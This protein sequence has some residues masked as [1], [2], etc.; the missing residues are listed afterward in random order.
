MNI[1]KIYL[2]EGEVID[3]K[4][5]IDTMQSLIDT[6]QVLIEK[7]EKL[8]AGLPA[9][10][11]RVEEV[12]ESNETMLLSDFVKHHTVRVENILRGAFDFD[13][14]PTLLTLTNYGKENVKKLPGMGLLSFNQVEEDLHKLGLDWISF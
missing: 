6:Q 13:L 8:R 2:Y 5:I 7:L 11:S 4:T 14:K 10:K 9:K 12:I 3:G 1:E